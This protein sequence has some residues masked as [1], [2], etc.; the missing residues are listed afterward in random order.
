V[1]KRQ[2]DH[3]G[4]GFLHFERDAS[5]CDANS[6]FLWRFFISKSITFVKTPFV[7]FCIS[8]RDLTSHCTP[9]I[10]FLQSSLT[11]RL[12]NEL[13]R[14]FHTTWHFDLNEMAASG[15]AVPFRLLSGD[16]V[17]HEDLDRA[18]LTVSSRVDAYISGSDDPALE[19]NVTSSF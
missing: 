14:Y 15:R 3:Y 4:T 13:L 19:E 5:S 12:Q 11:R 6:F 1:T 8:D 16:F 9:W 10:A 2:L 17:E 18:V 7:Q